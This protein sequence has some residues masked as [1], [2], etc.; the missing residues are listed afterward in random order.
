MED[1]SPERGRDQSPSH[2]RPRR[3]DSCLAETVTTCYGL[4]AILVFLA[5][6]AGGAAF[7]DAGAR[8]ACSC[9]RCRSRPG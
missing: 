8:L 9:R 5:D 7:A 4:V 1:L 3:Q 2:G 6:G